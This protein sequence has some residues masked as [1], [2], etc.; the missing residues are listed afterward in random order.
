MFDLDKLL[1]KLTIRMPIFKLYLANLEIVEDPTVKTAATSGKVIYYNKDFAS[2]ASEDRLLF[3]FSHEISHIILKHISRRE[4]RD[5][6]VWNIATDAVINQ[7]LKQNGFIIPERVVNFPNAINYSAEEYYD[8][9]MNSP[10]K[11]KIIEKYRQDK[12]DTIYITSHDFWGCDGNEITEFPDLSEQEFQS[13]NSKMISNENEQYI[14]SN[15]QKL[16]GKLK[17]IS[18]ILENLGTSK[19]KISWKD[20]LT[21]ARRRVI[22]A[23]YNLSNGDFNEEG[24]Y[25]YPYEVKRG[26]N[27][28]ILIDISSSVSDELVKAFLRECKNI[29]FGEPM[30]IG[31]F[32]TNFYGFTTISDI[33]DIDELII[34][35]R[36][37]TNFDTAV[38]AFTSKSDIRIIFTDGKSF[39]PTKRVDAIWVVYS[40]KQINPPG[41]RVINVNIDEIINNTSKKVR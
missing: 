12:R 19:S 28:E 31:F 34:Q 36:G 23:D 17:N 20:I 3:L 39:I 40:E 18:Y 11:E 1:K 32:D 2:N 26:C 21:I 9:I 35:G 14:N 6:L 24:I 7:I 41:G 27:V 4:N 16:E 37:G 5:L 29:F 33:S 8:Y 22:S 25:Q 15:Q 38:N 13:E 10:D 30:K